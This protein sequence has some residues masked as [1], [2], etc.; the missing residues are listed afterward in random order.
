[1][2]P[3]HRILTWHSIICENLSYLRT[4]HAKAGFIVTRDRLMW[5]WSDSN[6]GFVLHSRIM[7]KRVLFCIQNHINMNGFHCAL[8]NHVRTVLIL[9][10]RIMWKRTFFC[11][12]ISCENR[13]YFVSK[14]HRTLSP[15]SQ[16]I[17][18]P[19]PVPRPALLTS[20]PT[21]GA[22]WKP[23]V[24]FPVPYNSDT[25]SFTWSCVVQKK[26]EWLSAYENGSN[27]ALK[28]HVK[29]SRYQ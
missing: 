24:V 19:V 20:M 23:R 9:H 14:I 28:S 15:T 7:W 27:L 26:Q 18:V 16:P 25:I 12:Q 29:K 21:P 1:M 17:P 3:F 5:N 10:G 2:I 8:K 11:L 6:T 22:F 13:S 4:N